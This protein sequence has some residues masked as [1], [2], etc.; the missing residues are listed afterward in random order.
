MKKCI[1]EYVK[2][3]KQKCYENDIPDSVP[4]EI[5]DKV[6]SYKRITIAILKN[7]Y[8]LQTLGFTPKTSPYY[9]ELKRIEIQNRNAKNKKTF[10]RTKWSGK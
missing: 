10:K 2:D 7:D 5:N 4:N 8:A 9:T 1:K 6:P 3:W